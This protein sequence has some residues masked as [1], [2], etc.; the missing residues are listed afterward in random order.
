MFSPHSARLP[1]VSPLSLGFF[2]RFLNK[3]AMGTTWFFRKI[4][5]PWL[6]PSSMYWGRSCLPIFLKLNGAINTE[7]G[8]GLA[9]PQ[10]LLNNDKELWEFQILLVDVW[11]EKYCNLGKSDF[12]RQKGWNYPFKNENRHENESSVLDGACGN[13]ELY[14]LM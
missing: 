2:L 14:F 13:E 3:N 1:I 9:T 6:R 5:L 4:P 7:F 10:N 12:W 8:S 11:A